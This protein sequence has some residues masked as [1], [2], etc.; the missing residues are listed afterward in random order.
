[1]SL[2]VEQGHH[3]A[4]PGREHCQQLVNQFACLGNGLPTLGRSTR[5]VANRCERDF[6]FASAIVAPA[7]VA[8]SGCNPFQPVQQR[9]FTAI[10]R[11]AQERL[12]EHV[13]HES[14]P[15]LPIARE[16]P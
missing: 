4:I 9:S 11:Q 1:M 16:P 12:D 2:E 13:V 5:R 15:L 7:A 10:A 14:F 6:A 3:E 8:D